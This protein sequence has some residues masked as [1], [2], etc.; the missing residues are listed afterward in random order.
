MAEKARYW[1]GILYPENMIEDWEDQIASK[2]QLPYAYCIH[3]KCTEKD[4]ITPRKEHIH[5]MV[6]FPNTT[7]YKHALSVFKTLDKGGTTACNKVERVLGV[8]HMY[9]YLIHDT[10]DCRKKHKHLYEQSERVTGNNFDIGSYEQLSSTE[11]LDMLDELCDD[12]IEQ[13]FRNFR[14]FFLYVRENRDKEYRE[15]IK[16]NSG[17]LERLIRGNYQAYVTRSQDTF[18]SD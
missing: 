1:V 17:L 8:R 2:L 10:E 5:L 18:L 9:D 11:K 4:G 14:D 6:V 3:N 15:I 16:A 12:I 7:T 13:D